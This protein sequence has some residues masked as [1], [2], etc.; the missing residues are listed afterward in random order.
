[1]NDASDGKIYQSRTERL[2]DASQEMLKT[3]AGDLAKKWGINLEISFSGASEKGFDNAFKFKLTAGIT[4]KSWFRF[5]KIVTRQEILGYLMIKR[6][7][8]DFAWSYTAVDFKSRKA[9]PF[10]YY[11]DADGF[12]G[13]SDNLRGKSF[14]DAIKGALDAR[15]FRLLPH[16]RP[17]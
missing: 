17:A 15:R 11:V 10:H 2:R 4:T 14:S 13:G 3:V 9:N 16:L 6:T 12:D 8:F 5:G 7:E 1:M